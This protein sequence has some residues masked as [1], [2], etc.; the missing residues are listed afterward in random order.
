MVVNL[1]NKPKHDLIYIVD[2]QRLISEA[3]TKKKKD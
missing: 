1:Q 3:R 2:S